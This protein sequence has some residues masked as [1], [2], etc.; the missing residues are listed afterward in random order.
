LYELAFF[1]VRVHPHDH[2]QAYDKKTQVE[3]YIRI[4]KQQKT[5]YGQRAERE[6]NQNIFALSHRSSSEK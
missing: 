3:A 5:G 4:F 1:A 6:V 2:K